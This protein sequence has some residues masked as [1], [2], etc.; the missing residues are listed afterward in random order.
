MWHDGGKDAFM[1]LV[2]ITRGNRNYMRQILPGLRLLLSP[3]AEV[4]PH[5]AA[6]GRVGT[7][8]VITW[9]LTLFM[10]EYSA[11]LRGTWEAQ[12]VTCTGH[13]VTPS[14]LFSVSTRSAQGQGRVT[15]ID[16]DSLLTAPLLIP[17]APLSPKWSL[18]SEKSFVF[19]HF[20]HVE[21]EPEH[22]YSLL[23]VLQPP[24]SLCIYSSGFWST[25]KVIDLLFSSLCSIF[26]LPSF[27][28]SDFSPC[29]ISD[30]IGL[31]DGEKLSSNIFSR[32]PST[33]VKNSIT[34]HQVG[35]LKWL[36]HLAEAGGKG[37]GWCGEARY[38]FLYQQL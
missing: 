36:Y 33:P 37:A 20:P 25:S 22:I 8:L 9:M 14:H 15:D 31:S 5:K 6:G 18:N 38:R 16:V 10:S 24:A 12:R 28:G 30:D 4:A 34:S 1:S 27:K 3:T 11:D 35:S 7:C 2:K 13:S 32:P 17:L 19:W 26:H 23:F 29:L 21:Q